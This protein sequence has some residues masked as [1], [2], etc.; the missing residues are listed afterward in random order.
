MSEQCI[1][2][3]AENDSDAG[4][5][6]ALRLRPRRPRPRGRQKRV[7]PTLNIATNAFFIGGEPVPDPEWAAS[8]SGRATRRSRNGAPPRRAPCEGTGRKRGRHA[9]AGAAALERRAR[10][11]V[12]A[13]RSLAPPSRRGALDAAA[14]D[15]H[16]APHRTDK[17]DA[18]MMYR[19]ALAAGAA[20]VSRRPHRQR[21]PPAGEADAAAA[22]DAA[23]TR[24]G[25]DVEPEVKLAARRDPDAEAAFESLYKQKAARP[26]PRPRRSPRLTTRGASKAPSARRVPR[27]EEGDRRP[28]GRR[29]GVVASAEGRPRG[30]RPLPRRSPRLTRVAGAQS[31]R[32]R[33]RRGMRKETRARD[34]TRGWVGA[35]RLRG[36]RVP[37]RAV[38]GDKQC[39]HARPRTVGHVRP[40]ATRSR[41]SSCRR[42]AAGSCAGAVAGKSR[43]RGA[44]AR[45][46][47]DGGP[48]RAPR[49]RQ[50]SGAGGPRATARR[51]WPR[52]SRTPPRELRHGKR[53]RPGGSPS[54]D[55]RSRRTSE[56]PSRRSSATPRRA[57]LRRATRR[58]TS[59]PR[60][61]SASCSAV[62]KSAPSSRRL[63]SPR[64]S[65]RG[66]RQWRVGSRVG[67]G[68]SA[69]R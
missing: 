22:V 17:Q 34:G 44:G 27:N 5:K 36:A 19:V 39:P 29:Q 42:P 37:P 11:R 32:R 24:V 55:H 64:G 31:S 28:G 25:A 10:Q 47:S 6:S 57:H 14:K 52:A 40:A 49:P 21:P 68:A 60:C 4:F 13:P 20:L 30:A 53:R 46:G 16:A 41:G 35:T 18:H 66:R 58:P 61:S 9:A 65:R 3:S 67:G 59:S 63:A 48:G 33:R 23:A 69:P 50:S 54:C 51:R 62:A 8:R 56:R 7:V 26:R 38:A 12:T 1:V 2:V 15:L 43:A 45:H